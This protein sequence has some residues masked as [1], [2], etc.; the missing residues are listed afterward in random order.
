MFLLS[1]NL[2]RDLRKYVQSRAGVYLFSD[3][4]PLTPRNVQQILKRIAQ[5]ANIKKNVTPHKLRHSFAT[6]LLESGTDVRLIQEL[7][8]HS[9][10]RTTQIYTRVSQ[11][12]LKKVKSPMDTL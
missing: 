6:H 7:L 12:Q 4:A 11:E 10:L 2:V 1:D 5:K 3:D 8:V 9:D